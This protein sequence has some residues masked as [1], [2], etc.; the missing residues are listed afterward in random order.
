MA[1]TDHTQQTSDLAADTLEAF[2]PQ[3]NQMIQNADAMAAKIN[4]LAQERSE[5]IQYKNQA[6]G[7]KRQ[8]VEMQHTIE[9][10]QADLLLAE[11]NA[12]KLIELTKDHKKLSIE[13]QAKQRNLD[14]ARARSDALQKELSELKGGDNPKRLKEQ[15]KRIKN[16]S[17]EKD[18]QI[19][20]L[21][22]EAKQYRRDIKESQSRLNMAIEKIQQ[23]QLKHSNVGIYHSGDY[24]L[25]VW[26]QSTPIQN[27]EGRI[28]KC[29]PLLLMHQSG[30]GRLITFD[31]ETNGCCIHKAPKGGTRIPKEIEQFAE[32]WLFK[33]NSIQNGEIKP[34]DLQSTN[35]NAEVA[36]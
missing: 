4:E 8:N 12:Y 22:S 3:F 25:I 14:L 5:L 1:Q 7:Y 31:S 28:I 18:K 11:Q 35:L 9:R 6:E 10:M 21:K 19:A 13:D 33:V 30:T 2:I 20:S 36:A 23:L 24:H 16:K 29:Q 17:A 32:D 34:E 27:A 26:P 15:I